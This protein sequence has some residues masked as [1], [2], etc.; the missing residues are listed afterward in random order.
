MVSFPPCDRLRHS[1]EQ[2]EFE[3]RF[4]IQAVEPSFSEWYCNSSNLDQR[5]Q[6][7]R[8]LCRFVCNRIIAAY[9][10]H[11]TEQRCIY[12]NCHKRGS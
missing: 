3:G 8:G 1:L 10:L 4:V 11:K 2:V 9:R 12:Q 6:S 5:T 7:S